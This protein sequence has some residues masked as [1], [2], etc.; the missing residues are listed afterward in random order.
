MVEGSR[1]A[2]E[3]IGTANYERTPSEAGNSIFRRSIYAVRDIAAGE[4]LSPDS[5][6]VIRPGNGLA[7]RH[8]DELIGKRA[9]VAIARG[10]ALQW[11]LVE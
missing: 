1:V 6:R 5:I 8:F 4:K 3:A 9:R 10:T 11:E 2:W 7:P